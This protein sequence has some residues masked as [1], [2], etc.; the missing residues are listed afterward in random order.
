MMETGLDTSKPGRTANLRSITSKC[1]RLNNIGNETEKDQKVPGRGKTM[2]SLGSLVK[3]TD[4][5]SGGEAG[6]KQTQALVKPAVAV[7]VNLAENPSY[8]SFHLVS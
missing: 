4:R 2:C 7:S 1:P 5:R 6:S 3:P 8:P